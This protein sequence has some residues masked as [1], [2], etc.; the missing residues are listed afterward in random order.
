MEN[1]RI[2]AILSEIA[3]LLEL[4]GGDTFRIRAYRDAA[5]SVASTS[6]RLEELLE[7]GED[8]SKLPSI[9]SSTAE[10][11]EE[12]V[13]TGT[14]ARLEELRE[15]VPE[16]LVALM[17]VPR[18]GARKA[19]QLHEELGV[20]SLDE[21]RA[22]CEEHRVRE[23]RGMGAKTEENILRGITTV[24]S[25][26][27]RFSLREAEEHV[28][29]LERR[30]GAIDAIER[31][32]VA[33]SF[34]RGRETIGDLDVLV[35]TADRDAVADALAEADD[36]EEV[37]GRGRKKTSVRLAGG[38]QVDV[39]FV[40]SAHAG[41]AL[42]Y[43]TGSKAHNVALRGRAQRKGWKLNEY[44]LF[45]GD[46]R[47]AGRTEEAVY[48]RLGLPWIPPEL[49]EDRGEIEAAEHDAL[50]DLVEL[51][52]I[53]GDL[54]CHTS[55]T[56]GGAGLEEMVD[57]AVE[58]GRRY[59]AITDHSRAVRVANGMDAARLKKHAARIRRLDGRRG[60]IRL[61]A[62]VEVDIL[63]DGSL[64]LDED[65]LADLDWVVA[66]VH[67]R[68]GMDEEAMTERLVRA[69][70][71]GVVDCLGHPTTRAIGERDP[72]RFDAER[73][74]EACA[75]HG[76][77]L[78]INSQPSR[79]DLPDVHC[80]RARELG[81]R[82]VVSTDAHAPSDFDRMSLG[83]KTARRGWVQRREVL[84][85]LSASRFCKRIGVD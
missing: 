40:E 75:E 79:L 28:G 31:W 84:N 17:D 64:D 76:V 81:V 57:A 14:C 55:E 65:V 33:G 22:A 10:K 66:S 51:R 46:R 38:L 74:F 59:L 70:G 18:L 44:G 85:T 68:M 39:R 19:M 83:V 9:G 11:I 29:A 30:L 45:S 35:Q 60:D 41:A 4:R 77:L 34:R 67:S 43:F 2:A 54:H 49:R 73:V 48:G 25:A 56:D 42:L 26:S 78:E 61:L 16:A 5:R 20:E 1:S 23:L 52:Q 7:A 3:D 72:A 8:L 27:D 69:V 15:E 36:V 53:K 58:R 82:F 50:P 37:I 47:L 63:E 24:S 13:R 21:L 62:G 80:Q 6:A 32:E 12:I 71:S